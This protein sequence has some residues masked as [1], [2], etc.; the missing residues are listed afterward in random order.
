MRAGQGGGRAHEVGPNF[1]QCA[2]EFAR[3]SFFG[4]KCL[5][6]GSMI[7]SGGLKCKS[8]PD[9]IISCGDLR[10]VGSHR[11]VSHSR[12]LGPA[13]QWGSVPKVAPEPSPYKVLRAAWL[14]AL[15]FQK[16]APELLPWPVGCADGWCSK[17][18][19]GV[20]KS[21]PRIPTARWGDV[22]KVGVV[23]QKVVPESPRLDGVV[24]QKLGW[25]SKKLSQNPHSVYYY[26]SFSNNL[27]L[28]YDYQP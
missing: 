25:C 4:L 9:M 16:V 28:C 19:G 12:G 3:E 17:S 26:Y 23:L 18:W 8:G 7:K 22:P 14:V 13:A 21:C 11:K 15:V 6:N 10:L 2:C 24:F 5:Q 27:I 20:P 1:G